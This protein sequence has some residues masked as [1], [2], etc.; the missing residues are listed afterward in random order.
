MSRVLLTTFGSLGDLHPYIA[1][2]RALRA[3]GVD[4]C[5]AT[6]AD[7]KQ[8]VEAA[9]LAFVAVPPALSDLG[10]AEELGRW[11]FDP[12]RGTGRL[13]R[14][15]VM[16]NI[17]AAHAVLMQAA[18]DCDLLV[19]H[20]LTFMTPVVAT[21]Q[22]KPWLSS[23]LAPASLLSR[24]DPP[25]LVP[26]NVLQIA[27]RLGP[28]VYDRTRG[29]VGRIARRWER[30]LH[31]LRRELGLPATPQSLLFEGQFSPY[32]TLGLFDAPLAEPRPDWPAGMT[33][34]GAP[35]HDGTA[36]DPGALA[37]LQSFLDA[38]EPPLVFA[39]GS[40]AVWIA[41]DFWPQAIEA[42]QRLQRRAVLITGS[43]ASLPPLPAG[44]SAF[45]YLPYSA[46]FPHAA[47]VV[48]QAGVGT[49]SQALRAGRPQL[50]TPVGFDQPDNAA[51]AVT[52]GLARTLRFQRVTAADLVHELGPLLNTPAYADQ[53]RTIAAQL[54]GTDGAVI[55]ARKIIQALG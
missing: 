21:L 44:I 30:P 5:V 20:Q 38:G 47:A 10:N 51:R 45:D 16:P 32:G 3:Q 50:L 7:Y 23:V 55:A 42:A 18:A 46:V 19:S 6:S 54:A 25:V 28:W 27:R 9:G 31:A 26:L 41:R 11:L 17:R 22:R 43:T 14:G 40:A 12:L 48:H 49:L 8:P 4:V 53:A 35:L 52:L 1:V 39:L 36:A 33:V 2:G 24:F 37:Q 34:C 29:M 13:V 15:I